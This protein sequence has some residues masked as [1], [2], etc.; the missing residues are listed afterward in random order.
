M[1]F[2]FEDG[3][4]E[5]F[6]FDDEKPEVK[7]EPEPEVGL[8]KKISSIGRSII[9]GAR[10]AVPEF[11]KQV[12]GFLQSFEPMSRQEWESSL[13]KQAGGTYEQYLDTH[14][15]INPIE[16]YLANKGKEL[17][18][19]KPLNIIDAHLTEPPT[20]QPPTTQSE[21][22]TA[23]YYAKGMA[24]SFVN[25]IPSIAVSVATRRPDI[26][27]SLMLAQSKGG[28]YEEG[29]E[30][31]LQPGQ[32]ELYSSLT[33]LAEAAPSAIPLGVLLKPTGK[34][35]RDMASAGISEGI[36][37]TVTGG[38][39]A[40]ID[41][42]YV[43]PDMTLD[44]AIERMIDGAIIG[45][46]TG[47]MMSLVTSTPIH[48]I[49]EKAIEKQIEKEFD[50]SLGVKEEQE[51]IS[52]QAAIDAFRPM[53]KLNLDPI[54]KART[55]D[56]ALMA[57]ADLM[58][59]TEIDI[60]SV[61]QIIEQEPIVDIPTEE[62]DIKAPELPDVIEQEPQVDLTEE[63]GPPPVPPLPVGQEQEPI[64]QVP[65]EEVTLTP[66]EQPIEQEPIVEL[67]T[68]PAEDTIPVEPGFVFEDEQVPEAPEVAITE[69]EGIIDE[70]ETAEAGEK[71]LTEIKITRDYVTDDGD[72]VRV[73][74][75]ADEVV[76]DL[77]ARINGV[78][79][80]INCL[81]K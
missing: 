61:D 59:D 3:Q 20:E 10:E 76:K 17:S 44:Q 19:K 69:V 58:D 41:K 33:G 34:F 22:G 79:L 35:A 81:G 11:K 78:K 42:G 24:A 2:E 55:L 27:L 9:S 43:D 36:Q 7:V 26:G 1:P 70:V 53:E 72:T 49:N 51:S 67:P 29:R 46:G 50:S 52:D 23:E 63:L 73:V 28:A 12:A 66:V 80:L 37:E 39:Q 8:S 65:E 60:P 21:R 30:H 13:S 57:A 64:V 25:M 56:E 38:L 71:Q 40:A 4:P 32:A 48:K 5:K 74:Q 54:A 62:V 6:R 31:G 16:T 45:A 15:A 47:S 75:T 14:E 68:E 18:G 77:D